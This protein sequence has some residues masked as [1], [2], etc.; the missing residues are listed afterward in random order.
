MIDRIPHSAA[1]RKRLRSESA[2]WSNQNSIASTA[3]DAQDGHP[4]L[5]GVERR[6]T[7]LALQEWEGLQRDGVPP[8]LSDLAPHRNALE[9]ADRFLLAC[10][11]VAARSVFVLCGHRVETSFGQRVIG[12]ALCDIAPRHV[13]LLRACAEARR[14]QMPVEVEET[15]PVGDG[16][17]LTYRAVVMPVRGGDHS[18]DYLMGAYGCTTFAP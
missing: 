9:W 13:S 11:P 18:H 5:T 17:L 15:Q 7:R 3:L 14:L 8:A 4:R 2:A 12:Q 6:M 10:D 1:M 16:N